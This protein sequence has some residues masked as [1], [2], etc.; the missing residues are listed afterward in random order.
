M[1]YMIQMIVSLQK[2]YVIQFAYPLYPEAKSKVH[3]IRRRHPFVFVC[4]TLLYIL[5]FS[6]K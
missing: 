6:L 5:L 2:I 1:F 3:E 4:L